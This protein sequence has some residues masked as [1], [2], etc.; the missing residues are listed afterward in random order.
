MKGRR[1]RLCH[2]ERFISHPR[3]SCSLQLK[4]AAIPTNFSKEARKLGFIEKLPI[5][6]ICNKF[7]E[8]Q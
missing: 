5:V 1:W 8:K 3:G 2:I 7:N 4:V 6:N